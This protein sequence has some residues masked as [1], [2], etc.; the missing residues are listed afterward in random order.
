M[1]HEPVEN[2]KGNEVSAATRRAILL[3]GAAGLA[4]LVA[5]SVISA[6]PAG[7]TE[8]QNVL[9]GNDNEGATA[10]TGIF[11][12]GNTVLA[13]L[14]DGTNLYGVQGQDN[15][16]GADGVG[17]Y[18]QSK[19]GIGVSGGGNYRAFGSGKTHGVLS[20]GG[21]YGVYGYGVNYGVFGTDQG[22]FS[23]HSVAVA[24]SLTDT[25]NASPA[26]QAQTAGTGSAVEATI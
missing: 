15:S 14:A 17:V 10:R 1:E 7:A 6:Q 26:V 23:H 3:G 18:G 24:A 8:G 9:L 19:N 4:G 16:T 20:T 22:S 21:T 11:Y 25:S 13:V 12:T 5:D 2:D